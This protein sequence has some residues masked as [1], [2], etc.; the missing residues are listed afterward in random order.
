MRERLPGVKTAKPPFN[1][2]FEIRRDTWL[3]V[4]EILAFAGGNPLIPI[5]SAM[6]TCWKQTRDFPRTLFL[7]RAE[8]KAITGTEAYRS[9]IKYTGALDADPENPATLATILNLQRV[10]I[11]APG[12]CAGNAVIN[13]NSNAI[14]VANN[15]TLS[16]TGSSTVFVAAASTSN[17]TGNGATISAGLFRDL[18]RDSAARFAFAPKCRSVHPVPSPIS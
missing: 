9:I 16:V 6:D 4:R 1:E 10:V 7:T 17:V 15:D 11:E 2:D 3:D 12:P 8:M 18:D 5:M 13:G 14:T